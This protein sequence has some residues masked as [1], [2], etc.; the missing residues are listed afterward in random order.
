LYR[1]IINTPAKELR[2]NVKAWKDEHEEKKRKTLEENKQEESM[3]KVAI[4]KWHN[5][6]ENLMDEQLSPSA[7]MMVDIFYGET[8]TKSLQNNIVIHP[9]YFSK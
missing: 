5:Y 4:K 8:H 6:L 1:K 3:S 2:S 7:D 9:K